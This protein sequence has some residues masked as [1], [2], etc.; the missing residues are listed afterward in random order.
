V[1]IAQDEKN[2]QEVASTEGL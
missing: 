2:Y 1:D